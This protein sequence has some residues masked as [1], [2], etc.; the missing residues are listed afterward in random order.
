LVNPIFRALHS[1]PFEERYGEMKTILIAN[2]KGG[3]G[4]TAGEK[5]VHSRATATS[6]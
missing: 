4:K 1:W 2:P 5:K 3:S 6:A